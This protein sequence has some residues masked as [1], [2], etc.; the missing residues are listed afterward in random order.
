V[1]ICVIGKYPPIQGGVSM[2]TYWTAYGL[3]ARG[4]E[5]HVI[6]NAKEALP[7]FRMHMRQED[8]KRCEASFGKG[9]VTVH[10]TDPVDRSQSYIPMASPF[11]TK[12]AGIAA[13]AHAAMPFD[14]IFSHYME[15]YGIAGYLAAQITGLPHVVRM[16]GSDSGRLWHHPQFEPAYDHVLRSAQ[17]VIATGA[18]ARRAAERGV[19]PDRI[20]AGGAYA[21]CEDLFTP[22]GPR[23][24]VAAL[25]GELSANPDLGDALWGDLAKDRPYFGIY[26][27]LGEN[28][29]SFALLSA[30]RRL[31]HVGVDVGLVALAHGQPQI[32]GRFRER[33]RELGL[34]DRVL[35]IPFLPHWR[36]PEFL[37]GCLAVC[38]LEQN[39]PIGHHSPIIPLETLLCGKCLIASAEIIRKLPQW[40]RLPHGYGCVAIEDVN[41]IEELS[42]KLAAILRDPALAAV[43]GARGRSFALEVQRDIEFP[44]QLESILVS[45]A[46][47]RLVSSTSA[48]A[49]SER[50]EPGGRFRLTRMAASALKKMDADTGTDLSRPEETID[51]AVAERILAC[52]ERGI[53]E[54]RTRLRPLAAA[55]EIEIA[56]AAAERECDG[57]FD[58]RSADLLFRLTPRRWALGEGEVAELVAVRQPDLRVVQFD[59]DVAAFRAAKTVADFPPASKVGSSAIVTFRGSNGVTREPLLIDNCTARILQL[60]DGTRTVAEIVGELED[61]YAGSNENDL[62]WI[63]HLFLSGLIRLQQRNRKTHA[64]ASRRSRRAE[65]ASTGDQTC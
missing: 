63:E 5:V 37:R 44:R 57:S 33:A 4:H 2:R 3:A 9:S 32:E 15:P 31:K 29:G 24:D 56:I 64:P 58:A 22:E 23:L 12:L 35:Q 40:E 42:R 59:Y 11:V 30:L 6:T 54:G 51:L 43:V 1:R 45:A 17:V 10:W 7:P 13:S 14:V 8:W 60:S 38:C 16:A 36:V 65:R 53:A 41:D 46:K 19:G 21:L 34:S 47:R 55:V 20:A 26:G 50:P 39:F 27:K 62:E 48:P 18:V 52:I 49:A 61:E 25:R 28:K